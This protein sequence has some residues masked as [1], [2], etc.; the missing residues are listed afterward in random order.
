MQKMIPLAIAAVAS[1]AAVGCTQGAHSATESV[2]DAIKA[3]D[4]QWAKDYEAKDVNAINAH[5]VSDGVQAG[6]GYL[7][8][9]DAE[10]R[11]VLTA[12]MKD[13][14]YKQTFTNDR[15]DVASSGDLA[16]SRGQ[17]TITMTDPATKQVVTMPGTYLTIYKKG[18]DDSW[19]AIARF[20]TRGPVPADA[21][22]S[23]AA[24]GV[25]T[26][27]ADTVANSAAKETTK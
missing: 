3:Q 8:T 13:P 6:P 22:A 5:F 11:A 24:N 2:V 21:A 1:L 19:K 20:L 18:E 25:A 16:A 12:F 14:T 9:T 15:V 23:A 26:G 4:A 17:F 27:A 10:R 7:V